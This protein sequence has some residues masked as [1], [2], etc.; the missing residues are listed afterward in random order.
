[1]GKNGASRTELNERHV[2]GAALPRIDGYAKVTGAAIFADDIALPRML[3]GKLLRSPHAHARILSIDYANALRL[4]GVVAIAV[5]SDLPVRYGILPST[6]DETVFAIDKVRYIGEPVAGIVA[7]DELTAQRAAALVEV[8]YDAL[9]SVMSIEDALLEVGESGEKIHP[10][11]RK[12]SNVHKDV[13]L[14]FGDLEAGFAGADRIFEDEY[15]FEGNTHAALE[16][17]SAVASC[18]ADGKLTL[19][20]ST[21]TPH[22]LHRVTAAVLEMPA[23][24]IRII[25]PPVG[26]GFG[27]K[28]EPVA[29]ELAAAY[30]ARKTG[31]PV[32][33]TLT[34]EEVFYT[35]R[36]R[37]PVR[38]HLQT[39]I[40]SDGTIAACR[41]QTWLDGGA[42]GSYGVATTYYTGALLPVTYKMGAYAFDGCRVYTNK[43]PCGPK[44]GHGT[45]QPRYAFESQLDS[46]A[47]A[48][49]LDA[50]AYRTAIAIDPYSR[51]VNHLRVTSCGMREALSAVTERTD[52]GEKHGK[53]AP[54][55]GI[56]LA[57]S[58][59]L[60]GAG[61]PIY[62]NPMPHSGAVVKVDRGGGVTVFCGASDCGQG[63][64]NMLAVIVAETLGVDVLDVSVCAGDTD[65]TPVD[66]G[67]Y[68]SR[69]TFMAGNAARN[70]AHEVRE[71]IAEAAGAELGIAPE[72]CAFA[73]GRVFDRKQPDH[74]LSFVDAARAA[75]ARFGTLA[76]VG[77]YTPPADL[78][79]DFKGSGVGPSPAYSYS[80]CVAEVNVDFETGEVRVERIV[81][82]HDCGRALNPTIVEGQIEGSAYM[83][84][85]EALMEESAFR[86]DLHRIP[87]LLDY[88]TP[89]ILDTPR[90]EAIVIETEE[91]EG[92]YGAKEAGEGPLNPVIPAIANAVADA[93]GARI[94][95]TPI[96][97]ERV[98]QALDGTTGPLRLRAPVAVRTA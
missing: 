11:S 73:S 25:A 78:H 98:L 17:H 81:L 16:E 85:G 92:P 13:H 27:G 36:G 93:I 88:K 52:Y 72:R 77:S 87:N 18:G 7:E 21:Q 49:G 84:M 58:A 69:V 46:I 66:L 14:A 62:W 23:S 55:R 60:C 32:K 79:G 75:E 8:R 6:Q 2:V 15:F 24:R 48:L 76:G 64:Q 28:T 50:G 12:Q 10:E 37:H 97:P 74:A 38:I 34:R 71:R 53:L 68:S 33:F 9:P 5:G 59:Y 30:F 35:H 3:F 70:A 47:T 96:T 94:Y 22:Y 4:P 42:Y 91:L 54:G 41:L 61:L 26:G 31:R 56:G 65:L 89:T 67:S 20:S 80:A 1:M 40:T 19:W 57:A 39:G 29:H 43:P 95:A 90:I 45:T 44:R 83:G 82:A 51:T 63:S 86:D